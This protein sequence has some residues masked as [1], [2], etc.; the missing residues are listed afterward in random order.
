[1]TGSRDL[2]PRQDASAVR[3]RA[4][5]TSLSRRHAPAIVRHA[6]DSA[7]FAWEEFFQGE[8]ANHHTRKNYIHAV[9]KFL[10]WAE[11]H[12]LELVR[13]TPGDVGQY[14]Q[15]LP[16]AVPT[17]K[18]HLA[19]LRKFFDRMVNRHVVV[20]NPA[21][22]VRAERYS[23]VEGKTAEIRP[24][25]ARTLLR[26]IDATTTVGRRDRCVLSV[27]IYTAARV[28]AVARLGI[29]SLQY[30]GSQYSLRFVEKGNKAREI[31]VRHD[32]QLLLL[33]YINA[34]GITEGPLFCT[35]LG[36][37]DILTNRP[38]TGIDICRMM[39]RRLREAGLPTHYSP[40]SFRVATVT[41][42]LE[43][44]QPLE[45]VQ[46]LA[47]HADPRTTRLYDRRRRKITRN[48]VERISI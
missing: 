48:I 17:K 26:S 25:Q 44:N 46:H 5:G 32:L 15:E 20:I 7:Q 34:A 23:V 47:G 4:R 14:F 43:Q 10:T 3:V 39:K 13:I 41:D 1:M 33:D 29:K 42:L 12:G 21:A 37:T 40:H 30:D 2:I 36:K 6:G 8:I 28:G 27:L 45:D 38:M 35:A 18:L 19:A 11:D 24:D 16:L 22:T 31:P 9:R